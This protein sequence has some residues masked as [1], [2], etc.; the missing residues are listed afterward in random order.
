M[1]SNKLR[2][3]YTVYVIAIS[4]LIIAV[5]M[6]CAGFVEDKEV[7]V[8]MRVLGA[9]AAV[10]VPVG[11]YVFYRWLKKD[12]QSS[13]DELEQLVITKG[14]A[15]AGFIALTLS[16][17][18]SLLSFIFSGAAGFIMLGYMAIIGGTLKIA[19]YCYY[20]KF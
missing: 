7:T 1:K 17:V 19:V 16:P 13:S 4:E 8:L 3:A 6:I 5:W 10:A 11:V 2:R 18:A 9:I 15:L 14:F 20:K 12:N